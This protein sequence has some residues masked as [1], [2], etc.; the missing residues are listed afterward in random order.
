MGVIIDN[1]E[2]TAYFSQPCTLVIAAFHFIFYTIH[3]C[4]M[5][6]SCTCARIPKGP[7]LS[8]IYGI[9]MRD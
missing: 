1:S 4:N 5:N 3:E 8:H 6:I 2:I 9:L 7:P